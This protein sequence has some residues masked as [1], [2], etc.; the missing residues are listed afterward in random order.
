MTPVQR[1][2]IARAIGHGISDKA[3]LGLLETIRECLTVPEPGSH[4]DDDME[5][6]LAEYRMR[7]VRVAVNSLLGGAF[8]NTAIYTE[9]WLLRQAMAASPV[10]YPAATEDA[11]ALLRLTPAG[12]P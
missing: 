3:V 1:L 10:T 12:A 7:A 5:R 2:A 9:R 4:A 11:A 6:R 8:D